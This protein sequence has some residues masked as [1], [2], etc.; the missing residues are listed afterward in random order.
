MIPERETAGSIGILVG[1]TVERVDWYRF[2]KFGL[3]GDGRIVER[4]NRITTSA[5]DMFWDC[6]P[7]RFVEALQ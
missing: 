6:L 2:D 4:I 5:G 1:K 3:D 7:R